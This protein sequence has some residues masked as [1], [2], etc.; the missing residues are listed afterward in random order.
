MVSLRSLVS[1]KEG[2]N[3]VLASWEILE[4]LFWG[5]CLRLTLRL[6]AGTMERI[7]PREFSSETYQLQHTLQ[8]G[9]AL[10][11]IIVLISFFLPGSCH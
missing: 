6:H 10:I 9:V 7:C 1:S 5:H 2:R 11:H 4:P 3:R 8:A